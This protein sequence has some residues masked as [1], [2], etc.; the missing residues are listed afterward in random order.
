MTAYLCPRCA[1]DPQPEGF[2][3]PRRCAFDESGAFT[4]ENW[5]C[6]S[7]SALLSDSDVD[8]TVEGYNQS[9][10]HVR[11]Y[12]QDEDGAWD[13][14]HDGWIVLTR[15]KHRGCTSSAVHVGDFYPPRPVTLALVEASIVGRAKEVG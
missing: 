10:N 15:Y 14:G 8:C 9:M 3:S 5:N 7:L 4:S 11:A 13:D 2:G 1:E 12:R 6:A